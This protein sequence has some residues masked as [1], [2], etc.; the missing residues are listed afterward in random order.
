MAKTGVIYKIVCNDVEI[1]ECYVG[2][3]CNFRT[4]KFEHKSRCSNAKDAAYNKNVYQFIRANGNWD[5]WDMVM[6]EEFKHDTKLQLHS[7]ERHHIETLKATLNKQIPTRTDAEYHRDN[8]EVIL[9]KMKIYRNNN[10]E[11]IHMKKNVKHNCGCGGKY[12]TSSKSRHIKTKKHQ[13][14]APA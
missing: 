8:R 2:S 6:V 11:A 3:T 13:A 5:A 4:R 1:K 12:T 9:D 7:R 10:K 14:F